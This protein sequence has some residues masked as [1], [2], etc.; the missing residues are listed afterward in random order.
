M[1]SHGNADGAQ[2][3]PYC[4]AT[5]P[6]TVSLEMVRLLPYKNTITGLQTFL[7]VLS[8]CTDRLSALDK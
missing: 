4:G 6:S 3:G 2:G 8:S 5:F 7:H 1:R